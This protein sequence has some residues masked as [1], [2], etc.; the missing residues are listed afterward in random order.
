MSR[1]I[2][3]FIFLLSC[4]I[5]TAQ[6]KWA[7]V[8]LQ[9]EGKNMSGII[10]DNGKDLIKPEYQKIVYFDNF[11]FCKQND[12]WGVIDA[13]GKVIAKPIYDEFG[14]YISENLIRLKKD[15]KWGFIDLTG[16]TVIKFEYDFACNF[17]DQKAYVVKAKNPQ[18]IN[19]KGEIVEKLSKEDNECPENVDSVVEVPDSQFD[20][21][22]SKFIKKQDGKFGVV[23]TKG[24]I[25]IPLE[26][27]EIN[28]YYLNDIILVK[29][30]N[31]WGAYR[32]DGYKVVETKYTSISTFKV[33]APF[34]K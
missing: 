24:K 29:K 13:K 16:K 3:V 17:Y 10:L 15:N 34:A 11:Y 7:M 18:I 19:T 6:T 2:I 30:N 1:R 23:D 12:K 32:N 4:L 8:T 27:D 26:F 28:R 20:T 25:I 14:W 22:R 9:K 31:L 5:S 33:S 21:D